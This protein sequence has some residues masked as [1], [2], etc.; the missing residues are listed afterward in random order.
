MK[1]PEIEV[2]NGGREV[3]IYQNDNA[4]TVIFVTL[5]K[6]SGYRITVNQSGKGS[7]IPTK[8]LRGK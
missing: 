5:G 4:F 1:H 2:R 8:I 7:G 6:R 3:T